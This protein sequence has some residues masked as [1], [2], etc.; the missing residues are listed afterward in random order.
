M[1]VALVLYLHAELQGGRRRSGQLRE[2]Q[3][4]SPNAALPLLDR[5]DKNPITSGKLSVQIGPEVRRAG[6][7]IYVSMLAEGSRSAREWVETNFANT[8][9]SEMWIE[10]WDR[11][12]LVDFAVAKHADWRRRNKQLFGAIGTAMPA[13]LVTSL[14]TACRND[15]L[16]AIKL[17]RRDCRLHAAKSAC[18]PRPPVAGCAHRI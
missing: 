4:C 3:Q 11:A 17:L 9:G 8:R 5:R 16:A 1:S 18:S 6:P 13:W 14:H 7:E 2:S 10:M 12:S 15:G